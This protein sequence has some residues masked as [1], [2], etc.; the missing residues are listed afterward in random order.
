VLYTELPD[1]EAEVKDFGTEQKT[2]AEKLI[3]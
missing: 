1:R 3:V 2:L